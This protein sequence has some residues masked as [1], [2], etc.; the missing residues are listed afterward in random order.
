MA[1]E[2][3]LMDETNNNAPKKNRLV[4]AEPKNLVSFPPDIFIPVA[5]IAYFTAMLPPSK[6]S[7]T[8]D[9]VESVKFLFAGQW[10]DEANA[11]VIVR[12]WTDWMRISYNEKAKLPRLFNGFANLRKMMTNNEELFATPMKMLLEQNDKGYTK[13]IKVKPNDDKTPLAIYYDQRF[14]PYQKV[15]AFGQLVD[16]TQAVIK[17]PDGVK[18]FEPGEMLEG[19]WESARNG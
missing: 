18:V 13:I 14:E 5:P 19:D 1:E 10:H 7:E 2:T 3:N 16:M 4:G 11:P 6:F 17:T 8:N 12:K 9:M 15:K